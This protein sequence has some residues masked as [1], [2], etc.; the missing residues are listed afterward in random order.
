MQRDEYIQRE[1]LISSSRTTI[2]SRFVRIQ[3]RNS[4]PTTTFLIL[5]TRILVVGEIC[6]TPRSS[7]V[8]TT[9]IPLFMTVTVVNQAMITLIIALSDSHPDK[10][11]QHLCGLLI[12]SKELWEIVNHLAIS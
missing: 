9:V 2:I 3:N 1:G 12:F 7:T 6:N 5:G 4:T 11:I 10:K 8:I